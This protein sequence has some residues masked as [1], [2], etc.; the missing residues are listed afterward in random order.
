MSLYL[1][2]NLHEKFEETWT[3]Y[4][5]NSDEIFTPELMAVIQKSQVGQEVERITLSTRL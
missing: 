4:T 1:W 2:V 3:V 5:I